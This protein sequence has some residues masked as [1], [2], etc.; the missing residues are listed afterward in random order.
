M[1]LRGSE[2]K[3]IKEI[4]ESF[5]SEAKGFYLGRRSRR[6]VDLN[7]TV[8][9][10]QGFFFFNCCCL[11]F[12]FKGLFFSHA[13]ISRSVAVITAFMM[14]TDQFTFEKAYENLQTIKPEAK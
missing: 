12:Y 5:I 7:F 13:G 2:F 11:L 3:K 9:G 6:E 14:K 8:Y 10:K 1:H 4:K